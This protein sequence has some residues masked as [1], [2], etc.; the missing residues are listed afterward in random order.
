[1]K[2]YL[3]VIAGP[4]G[5]GKD[6]IADSIAKKFKIKKLPTY[7]TRKPRQGEKQ[8]ED[9]YFVSKA[10]FLELIKKGALLEY[11]IYND[12][13]Y[14]VPKKEIKEALEQKKRVLLVI[15]VLG[16]L[17]VK[18]LYPNTILIFI[19]SKLSDIKARLIKRGKESQE[20]IERR[21]KAAK[22]ELQYKKL[23]DY[24]VEN[25]E[26]HPEKAVEEVEKIIKKHYNN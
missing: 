22:K 12:N 5:V 3:F 17:N 9:Y 19:Q 2:P 15:G 16:G 13:Y 18:K 1:M 4:S 20:E 8:G 23:Y 26:G 10:N 24:I 21:L 14:G 6:T 25:P 7:T 11:E